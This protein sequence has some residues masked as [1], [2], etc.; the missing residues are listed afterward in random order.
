MR[1]ILAQ[2]RWRPAAS[3]AVL[4]L[5]IVAIT[6]SALGPLY[7]RSAEESVVKDAVAQA[8]PVSTGLVVSGDVAGQ[9]QFTVD[10]LAAEV[11]RTITAPTVRQFYGSPV[12][13]MSVNDI[14]VA[15]ADGIAIGVATIGWYEAQCE[16]ARIV[17]GRCP[18]R[19]GE[20]MVSA[21]E[22]DGHHLS[23]GDRITVQMSSVDRLDTVTVV[24]SYDAASGGTDVWGVTSPA[25]AAPAVLPGQLPQLDEV[26][27]SR[28]QL[29]AATANTT[30]TAFLPLRS[31]RVTLDNL[32]ALLSG[33]D[34]LERPPL[35]TERPSLAVSSQVTGVVAATAA[36]RASARQAAVAITV[37]LV[38]LAL[39]VLFMAIAS[40]SEDRSPEIALAKLRG[41][42]PAR[43]AWFGLGPILVL[44]VVAVPVGVVVA[45]A[46][47]RLLVEGMAE[48][49][50]V[51]LDVATALSVGM[52]VLGGVLAS[53]LAARRML[54]T[55]VLQHLRRT[56]QRRLQRVG[57]TVVET[58]LLTLA[59]VSVVQLWQR[60]TDGIALLAPG[61]VSFAA[62]AVALHITPW[63]FDRAVTRSRRSPD[64]ARFLAA[65]S[66]VRRPGAGRL[67]TLVT[68]TTAL[69]V[70]AVGASAA[71]AL[72]RSDMARVALGAD[73]VLHVKAGSPQQLLAAVRSVD[74]SGTFAMA[75]TLTSDESTGGILTVDTRALQNVSVWDPSWA[76]LTWSQLRTRL[77]PPVEQPVVV[78]RRL[79]LATTWTVLHGG[80]PVTLR[81]DLVDPS[82]T[83]VEETLGTLRPGD[84]TWDVSLPSCVPSCRLDSLWLV[85]DPAAS[86]WTSLHARLRISSL[87]DATGPVAGFADPGRWRSG[88]PVGSDIDPS[89][90]QAVSVTPVSGALEVRFDGRGVLDGSIE[91]ADHPLYLPV[92]AATGTALT[93]FAPHGLVKAVDM[94]H[95]ESVA[96]LTHRGRTL[97]H[98]GHRGLL[99]DLTNATREAPSGV[100]QPDLQVWLAP[101]APATVV[102]QLGE[103]DVTVVATET[104]DGRK[105]TLARG[106]ASLSLRLFLVAA[107]IALALAVAG[108]VTIASVAARQ[109]RY[110]LTALWSLGT[111]WRTLLAAGRRERILVV[112][113]GLVL[114]ALVG[115]GTGQLVLRALPALTGGVTAPT[116]Y[117]PGWF[118][119]TMLLVGFGATLAV[120]VELAER[121]AARAIDADVLREGPA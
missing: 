63:V 54:T 16:G 18:Q 15:N 110:E 106:A 55:P 17:V 24:G 72:A 9:T 80:H 73:T 113:L 105:A 29:V 8:D 56:G 118:A 119:V 26:L 21:Q 89:T 42:S 116:S 1:L 104:L 32:D 19:L 57:G 93:P 13:S 115:L 83:P 82:G 75:A 25:Q 52:T 76:G 37:Q 48:G 35:D 64:V 30:V 121:R 71:V 101:D 78:S 50:G 112:A 33:I 22:F 61:L 12:R 81:A 5:A 99:A 7:A 84:Q 58:M 109:R 70:F 3:L 36:D 49:T 120:V 11:D 68:M 40:T 88:L 69:S 67:L 2:L 92:I 97:P 66:L 43:V 45:F 46:L 62:A 31:D 65:R 79:A 94:W 51:R 100:N 117:H 41:F 103:H 60:Q 53:A 14:T 107:A 38:A 6:A 27:V 47:D 77:A 98:L 86:V 10:D 34:Q 95:T 39:F 74:P 20:A 96:R 23:I 85:S 111:A 44:L 114:G 4:A 102:Q 87:S 108:L 59:A 91:V 28:D 90:H